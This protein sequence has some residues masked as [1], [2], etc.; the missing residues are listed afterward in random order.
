MTIASIAL[1]IYGDS[2]SQTII[3]VKLKAFC[4]TT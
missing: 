2:A 3:V 1:R 4:K